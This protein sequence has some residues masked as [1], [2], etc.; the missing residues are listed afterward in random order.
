MARRKVD[1]PKLPSAE[2]L[3]L[4]A[5][6]ETLA[7]LVARELKGIV[8]VRKPVNAITLPEM[9]RIVFAVVA[10]W[11]GLKIG[12]M[13]KGEQVEENKWLLS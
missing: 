7:R 9:K 8:E 13:R 12:R 10:H 6:Y 1:P 2:D 4:D 11:I 3:E 5:D